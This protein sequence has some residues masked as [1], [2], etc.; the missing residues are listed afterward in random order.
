MNQITKIEQQKKRV[1]R[2]S[3]YID[4]EFA[5]GISDKLLVDYDLFKGKELTDADIEK[6]KGAESI[7]KCLDK[8]YHFLSFRPR[9][10]KEMRDKLLEKFE[11]ETVEVAITKLKEYKFIDDED[12]A[13]M[14]VR[15]RGDGRGARALAFELK[16]KGIDPLTIESA[17]AGIDKDKEFKSA[18]ELVESKSKYKG[19]DRNEAYKKVG[20]FLS[21]RGFSYDIIKKVIEEIAPKG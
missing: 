7:T 1:G 8:A 11:P 12:F 14:W 16:R 10:E 20:G 18:L 17:L 9:S 6:I 15:S 13:N 19:L 5:F 21:R 3:I 4:G 2:V